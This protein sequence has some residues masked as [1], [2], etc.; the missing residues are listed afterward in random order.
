MIEHE[1]EQKRHHQE[2]QKEEASIARLENAQASSSGGP[3]TR[4]EGQSAGPLLFP[5]SNSAPTSRPSTRSPSPR[6]PVAV[7]PSPLANASAAIALG[8]G[9]PRSSLSLGESRLTPDVAANSG[10]QPGSRSGG[11]SR[12][13]SREGSQTT[14]FSTLAAIANATHVGSSLVHPNNHPSTGS[15]KSREQPTEINASVHDASPPALPVPSPFEGAAPFIDQTP[16]ISSSSGFNG[17]LPRVVPGV[18]VTSTDTPPPHTLH[19][20]EGSSGGDRTPIRRVNAPTSIPIPPNSTT[21]DMSTPSI[22]VQPSPSINE[23]SDSESLDQSRQSQNNY[24]I[25][26]ST[27]NLQMEEPLIPGSYVHEQDNT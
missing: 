14:P 3:S 17:E 10:S 25:L 6:G 26:P 16:A 21:P 19:I 22:M 15:S 27:P 4:P 5:Q 1:A 11:S 7:S 18:T 8:I 2:K 23:S 24:K 20:S 12:T 13:H 9:M